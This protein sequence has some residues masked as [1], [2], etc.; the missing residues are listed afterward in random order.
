MPKSNKQTNNAVG[1]NN[2]I[3]LFANDTGPVRF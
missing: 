1:I 3:N 2:C